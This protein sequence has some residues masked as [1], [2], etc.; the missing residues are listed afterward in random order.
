MQRRS[1]DLPEPDGPMMQTTSPL[2]T[3][4]ETPLMTSKA[5]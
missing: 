3:S 4:A 2:A 1:V 5:P